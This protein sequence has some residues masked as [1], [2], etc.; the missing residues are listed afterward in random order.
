MR[1]VS[2][3]QHLRRLRNFRQYLE[4][5]FGTL[6]VRNTPDLPVGQWIRDTVPQ[7]SDAKMAAYNAPFPDR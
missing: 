3:E 2:E 1:G 7:L 6:V 5:G 4:A